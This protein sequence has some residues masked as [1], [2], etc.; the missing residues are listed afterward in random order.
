MNDVLDDR[1]SATS[2]PRATGWRRLVAGLD[3]DGWR[4]PTPAAGWDIATQIAHLA[5]TDEGAVARRDRQ[6][7][8]GRGRAAGDRR[9]ERV[10][11]H[12]GA[13]RVPRPTPPAI[14]A[15]WRHG[16][17][18]RCR[19]RCGTTRRARSSPWFGPPMSP[20][21]MAT[22][23]FMETWAH[24]LDVA[25]ALGVAPSRPTGSGTSRTS[26][27]APATSPSACAGCEPPAEEFRVDLARRRR[28]LGVGPGGRRAD[29]HRVG[30]RLLPAGHPAP[31]PRR[32]RPGR[33]RRRRRPLAG[34]RAG[35][36]R[37]A[38]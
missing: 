38:G 26:A 28:G 12:R 2:P 31:A 24:A 16:A 17:G 10:R 27:C 33:R 7:G 36:R 14:L 4:T 29:G 25:E 19:R 1:C 23:R 32:P 15:R 20:T 3:E 30:V 21:S 35:V 5:W 37:S 34:H 9:P 22:A 18:A 6:G 11:R 13:R 8:V